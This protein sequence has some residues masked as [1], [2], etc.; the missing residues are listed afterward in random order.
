LLRNPVWRSNTGQKEVAPSSTSSQPQALHQA[1]CAGS[2]GNNGAATAGRQE[3][4]ATGL[5]QINEHGQPGLVDLEAMALGR[6]QATGGERVM[7]ERPRL[8][9]P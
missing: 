8:L 5:P 2:Y 6:D 9:K 3:A 4:T 7:E 1:F